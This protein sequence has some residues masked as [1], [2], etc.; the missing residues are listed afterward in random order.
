MSNFNF[1]VADVMERLSTDP[2]F[3]REF[4]AALQQLLELLKEKKASQN[5]EGGAR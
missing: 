2:Q 4:F 1:T 5:K 3:S